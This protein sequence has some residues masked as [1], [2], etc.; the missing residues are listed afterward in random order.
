MKTVESPSG[1]SQQ[2]ALREYTDLAATVFVG[3]F[4]Q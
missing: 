2:M 1:L 4:D 3:C